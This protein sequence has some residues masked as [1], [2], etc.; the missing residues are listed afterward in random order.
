M[1]GMGV[2][3]NLKHQLRIRGAV[4]LSPIKQILVASAKPVS[5]SPVPG[6]DS[7]AGFRGE[8]QNPGRPVACQTCCWC[9]TLF[10]VKVELEA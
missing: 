1:G 7:D 10:Q 5:P 2:H 9:R 4:A 6:T 8:Q 3:L